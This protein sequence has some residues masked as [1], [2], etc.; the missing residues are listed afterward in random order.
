MYFFD[1][2]YALELYKTKSI[3]SFVY[4]KILIYFN[5]YNKISIYY[6]QVNYKLYYYHY[7]YYNHYYC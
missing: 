1:Q 5:I 6:Y 7:W 2:I 4:T 3:L